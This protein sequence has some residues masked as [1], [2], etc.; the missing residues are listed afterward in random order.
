MKT[1]IKTEKNRKKNV[2]E[3][4]QRKKRVRKRKR[5]IWVEGKRDKRS[6]HC[7]PPSEMND[8]PRIAKACNRT[9][10]TT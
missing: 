8:P 3:K 4:S 6:A 1:E 9:N 2:R 10:R 5:K 7:S